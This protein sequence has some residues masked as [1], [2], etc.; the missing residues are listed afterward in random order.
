MYIYVCIYIYI[1][2]YIHICI[3]FKFMA[4]RHKLTNESFATGWS[5][6]RVHPDAGHPWQ[7][8]PKTNLGKQHGKSQREMCTVHVL[9]AGIESTHLRPFSNRPI[10]SGRRVHPDAGRPA[11]LLRRG[12]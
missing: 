1:Y 12:A 10:Q 11:L 8:V 6:R 5:G 4:K 7:Q 3:R 9:T 2:I